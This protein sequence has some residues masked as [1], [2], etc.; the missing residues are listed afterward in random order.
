M[1]DRCFQRRRRGR[2][3]PLVNRAIFSH[4]FT[5]IASIFTTSHVGQPAKVVRGV[6]PQVSLQRQCTAKGGE[7]G[8][9]VGSDGRGGKEPPSENPRMDSNRCFKKGENLAGKQQHW[10]S[11]LVQRSRVRMFAQA[12]GD[13]RQR[14]GNTH[15]LAH[16]QTFPAGVQG[17]CV[18]GPH[19][20]THT[21]TYTYTYTYTHL[22]KQAHKTNMDE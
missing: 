21:Y 4:A 12:G 7:V 6:R 16:I 14:N 22:H 9:T 8:A 5:N 2:P 13:C 1:V 17:S 15:Q 11:A 10:F 20:H 18:M 3:V 19:T